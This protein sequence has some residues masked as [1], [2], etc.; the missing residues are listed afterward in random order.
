MTARR[1]SAFATMA[2]ESTPITSRRSSTSSY[3]SSRPAAE[4]QE[5]WVLDSSLAK[6]LVEMHGGTIEAHSDGLGKGSEF[7]VRLPAALDAP[8][9]TSP[10]CS[11]TRHCVA[12]SPR[13]CASSPSTTIRTRWTASPRCCRRSDTKCSRRIAVKT[14]FAS[15]SQ[16]GRMSSSSTSAFPEWTGTRSQDGFEL[17]PAGKDI[18]LVAMTGWGQQQD[19]QKAIEAGFDVHL[20]KPADPDELERLL[21]DR[22]RVKFEARR[23][24]SN[25]LSPGDLA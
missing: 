3:R 19:K 7:V 12:L 10:A 4:L 24:A 13:R 18:F 22:A 5:A 20:T 11:R 16:S 6:S 23:A 2:S 15:S 17:F 8:E 14:H 21:E 9:A 1:S 25:T